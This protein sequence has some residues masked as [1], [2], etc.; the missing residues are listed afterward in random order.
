ME[1]SKEEKVL[2]IINESLLANG[3]I[4][5]KKLNYNNS[6]REDLEIDSFTM[7]EIV[8]KFEEEF[9]IDIFE[10]GMINKVED[11]LKLI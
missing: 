4:P 6:L 1:Y 2:R 11:L 10:G 7:V 9:G 3:K 5:I 8:V